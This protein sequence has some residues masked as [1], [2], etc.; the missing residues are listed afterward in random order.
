MQ[1]HAGRRALVALAALAVLAFPAVPASADTTAVPL[2]TP[3]VL[4]AD[5]DGVPDAADNCVAVANPDQADY[6]ANG[7]GDACDPPTAG[8]VCLLTESYVQG[9]ARYLAFSPSRRATLDRYANDL[10]AKADAIV[11]SLTPAQKASLL[12]QYDDA[13]A[14]AVPQGWLTATQAAT[15]QAAAAKL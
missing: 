1:P 15:L 13:V 12:T 2:D 10:C 7:A 3:V 14:R 5:A 11:A 6:D 8:G 9:S 4:D